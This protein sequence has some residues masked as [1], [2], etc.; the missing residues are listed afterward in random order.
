MLQGVLPKLFAHTDDE[1]TAYTHIL[2]LI[3]TILRHFLCSSNCRND[4]KWQKFIFGS[5]KDIFICNLVVII[6]T[7]GH[8]ANHRNE[9]YSLHFTQSHVR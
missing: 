2:V 7:E 5:N 8:V 9:R 4:N 6:R 1:N 3:L